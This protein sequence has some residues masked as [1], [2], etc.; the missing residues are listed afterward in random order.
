MMPEQEARMHAQGAG[1]PLVSIGMPVY[2]GERHLAEALESAL[3]QDHAHLEIIVSDNASSDA[4]PDLGRRYAQTDRRVRYHRNAA[5]V[6]AAA[7]FRRALALARG[8][9]FTWLAHDDVLSSRR[10]LSTIVAFLQRNRDVVLCGS[11]L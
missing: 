9:Y 10:Y 4:T 6:G 7:N 1:P 2:N 5:N 8:R 11:G 3:A